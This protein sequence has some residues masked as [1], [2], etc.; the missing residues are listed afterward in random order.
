MCIASRPEGR[1]KCYDGCSSV[2]MTFIIVA[3][4]ITFAYVIDPS[5]A[6]IRSLSVTLAR[7]ALSGVLVLCPLLHLPIAA[8]CE[9]IEIN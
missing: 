9:A 2:G 6:V 3:P 8:E 7:R 4:N 1:K 5:S